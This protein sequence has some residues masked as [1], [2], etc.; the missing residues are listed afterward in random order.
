MFYRLST[1]CCAGLS[2]S[3]C[4]EKHAR[5]AVAA[6]ARAELANIR[7]EI[8]NG[9]HTLQTLRGSVEGIHVAVSSSRQR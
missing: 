3:P 9:M 4:L 1:K 5:P 6:I 7:S 8:A 2:L